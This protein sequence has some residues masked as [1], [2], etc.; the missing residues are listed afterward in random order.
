MAN[1]QQDRPTLR[2]ISNGASNMDSTSAAFGTGLKALLSQ[3]TPTTGTT[4][5]FICKQLVTIIDLTITLN[6]QIQQNKTSIQD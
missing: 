4:V 3:I 5:I 1:T 6:E 2:N